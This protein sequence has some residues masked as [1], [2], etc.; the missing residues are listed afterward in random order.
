MSLRTEE[1]EQSFALECVSLSY[2]PPTKIFLHT[3]T[4]LGYGIVV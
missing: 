4:H 2:L 3:C 1:T